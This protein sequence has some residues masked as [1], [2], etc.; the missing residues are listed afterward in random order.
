MVAVVSVAD[1]QSDRGGGCGRWDAVD[2]AA[3]LATVPA[4]APAAPGATP[5]A[6]P[7]VAPTPTVGLGIAAIR[8]T[9]DVKTKP[10]M[11]VTRS[12]TFFEPFV[13]SMSALRVIGNLLSPDRAS[14]GGDR[15]GRFQGNSSH[16]PLPG[17]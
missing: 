1:A 14:N 6:A 17:S 11:A 2:A 13:Q 16:R 12:V 9:I 15:G 7:G 8:A 5:G 3:A 10:R 4:V